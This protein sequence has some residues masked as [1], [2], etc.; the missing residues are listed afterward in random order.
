MIAAKELHGFGNLQ[1]SDQ[2]HDG[3]YHTD[4]VASVFHPGNGVS[5]L[6]KASEASALTRLHGHSET[7]TGHRGGVDPGLAGLNGKIVYQKTGFEVV[8]TIKNRVEI[9][10]QLLDVARVDV[11]NERLDGHARVNSGQFAL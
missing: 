7:V 6:K 1:R 8:G 9:I 11:C 3:T 10:Q 2:I 5:S 4:G